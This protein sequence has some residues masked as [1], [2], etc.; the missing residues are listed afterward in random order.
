MRELIRELR[1]AK[2]TLKLVTKK[3]GRCAL[4]KA[5]VKEGESAHPS[6]TMCQDCYDSTRK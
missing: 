6:M 4:C 5:K 2:K 3:S 1:E